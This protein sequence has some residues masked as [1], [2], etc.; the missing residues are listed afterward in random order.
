M[1]SAILDCRGSGFIVVVV[2]ELVVGLSDLQ[3]D[4]IHKKGLL[5][6]HFLENIHTHKVPQKK[7][8]CRVQISTRTCKL[9]S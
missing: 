5:L 9:G 4:A 2:V 8:W 6:L 3:V 7:Y 1:I